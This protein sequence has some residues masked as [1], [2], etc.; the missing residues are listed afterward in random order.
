MCIPAC[1]LC[2]LMYL[3]LR[4]QFIVDGVDINSIHGAASDDE[5]EKEIQFFFPKEQTVAVIKPNAI[6]EK[7]KLL[8]TLLIFI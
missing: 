1:S 2:S 6:S 7:G 3:S 8:Q 5:A 4:A